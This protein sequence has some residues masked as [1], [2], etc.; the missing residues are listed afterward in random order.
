MA[1]AILSLFAVPVPARAQV[2]APSPTAEEVIE[3]AKAAYADPAVR[4]RERRRREGACPPPKPGEDI[5]VC[6]QAPDDPAAAGYDKERAERDYAAKTADKGAPRAPD[7]A[8]PP[9]VPSLLSLCVG[10]GKP[11]PRPVLIDLA[12]IPEAADDSDAARIARGEKVQ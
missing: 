7:F 9:C 5:V 6:A 11:L 2:P 3:Q 10:G 1:L 4:E 12:A 8:A